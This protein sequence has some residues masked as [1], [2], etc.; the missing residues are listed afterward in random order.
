MF[1][2][3]WVWAEMSRVYIAYINLKMWTPFSPQDWSTLCALSPVILLSKTCGNEYVIRIVDWA[4]MPVLPLFHCNIE[5]T[6][7]AEVSASQRRLEV[8]L[9]SRGEDKASWRLSG[10]TLAECDMYNICSYK[11]LPTFCSGIHGNTE[12]GEQMLNGFW[13]KNSFESLPV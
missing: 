2:G 11:L 12:H 9:I 10:P 6:W 3:L 4:Q 8:R 5:M 1:S 13:Y 7:G